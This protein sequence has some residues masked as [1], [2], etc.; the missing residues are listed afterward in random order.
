MAYL[1][2]NRRTLLDDGNAQTVE[3]AVIRAG[4][5]HEAKTITLNANN[6]TASVNCF[7]LTG[8]VLAFNIHGYIKSATTLTN[9]TNAHFD[10]WDGTNSVLITKATGATMSNFG[11]GSFFTKDKDVSSALTT[12]NNN[13]CRL[14]EAAVGAKENAPFTIVEKLA[15]TTYLRFI[16]TTTDAPINATAEIHIEFLDNAYGTIIQA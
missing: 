6:T 8:T 3:G 7:I 12:L 4:G 11:V 15:T 1:N 16:Y 2:F 5:K 14:N 9:L 10:L 13:Q